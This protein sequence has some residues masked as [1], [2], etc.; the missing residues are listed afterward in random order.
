MKTK[1]KSSKVWKGIG[2][3]VGAVA[4][5]E[6]I[7][8]ALFG[9][10]EPAEA[11]ADP[12]ED[13][14]IERVMTIED[15]AP[16]VLLDDPEP[17]PEPE[18]V[19]EPEPAYEPEPVYEPA[20]EPSITLYSLT[21]PAGVNETATISIIGVPGTEYSIAVKY[22]ES[23]STAKGLEKTTA[24]ENGWASWSWKVGG[25]VAPGDYKITITGGG[26]TFETWF[27]VVQ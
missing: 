10:D 23:Y 22:A 12:Q 3:F 25:N 21:T 15:P 5:V 14:G 20:Q 24:N 7:G 27:T 4:A 6:I 16:L 11:P 19:Y 18:P 17:E 26:E 8:G 1:G 13:T 2:I 9:S